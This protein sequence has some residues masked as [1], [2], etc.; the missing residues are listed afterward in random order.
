M[1]HLRDICRVVGQAP[2][3]LKRLVIDPVPVSWYD[4]S[5]AP[6]VARGRLSASGGVT[7]KVSNGWFI[8]LILSIA[9]IHVW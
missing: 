6:L 9:Y 1:A 7:R 8:K 3:L 4:A 5:G 2:W